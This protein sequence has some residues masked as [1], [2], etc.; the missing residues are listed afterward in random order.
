MEDDSITRA[1]RLV[2]ELQEIVAIARLRLALKIFDPNE[3]RWPKGRFDGGRWRRA[4]S[5]V[6]VAGKLDQRREAGCLEQYER[7]SDLCRMSRSA[8]CWSTAIQRRAA[9]IA[10]DYIPEHRH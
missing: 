10:G 1:K 3:P 6:L 7:D 9:C 2:A 8:L 5:A 4:D